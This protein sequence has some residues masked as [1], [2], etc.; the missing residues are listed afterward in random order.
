MWTL[1]VWSALCTAAS[2]TCETGDYLYQGTFTRK[3]CLQKLAAWELS[4]EDHRGV[5]GPTSKGCRERTVAGA[6]EEGADG[7]MR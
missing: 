1:I 6:Y 3:V 7:G 2:P 5:G 4:A